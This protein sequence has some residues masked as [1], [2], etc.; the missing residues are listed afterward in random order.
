MKSLAPIFADIKK[1]GK[2]LDKKHQKSDIIKKTM[3]DVSH[4][5]NEVHQSIE[6]YNS[7]LESVL[8][9]GEE[10]HLASLKLLP[11]LDDAEKRCSDLK[12]DSLKLDQ[13]SVV[14]YKVKELEDDIVKYKPTRFK[15]TQVA[16]ELI[17][18]CHHHHVSADLPLIKDE[19]QF[20][21][22]RW[23]RLTS[24]VEEINRQNTSLDKAISKLETSTGVIEEIIEEMEEVV[25]EEMPFSFDFDELD[26]A[27]SE[28]DAKLND[29]KEKEK[30]VS[31]MS[32]N[33]D[34]I[35]SF[36][37][38]HGGD[39]SGINNK[40]DELQRKW[41]TNKNKLSG[42]QEQSR[43]QAKQITHFTKSE[44]NLNDW[45][46]VI[47]TTVPALQTTAS[48]TPDEM[49]KH[50]DQIERIQEEIPK[51][52]IELQTCKEIGDWLCDEFKEQ[53]RPC[54]EIKNKLA[55]I[56]H[57]IEEISSVLSQQESKIYT[58][59]VDNQEFVDALE[60]FTS[61]LEKLSSKIDL[62]KDVSAEWTTLDLQDDK[63]RLIKKKIDSLRY[64][65][66]KVK[67][68]GAELK[69]NDPKSPL[70]EKI[71]DSVKRY[72]D[73]HSNVYSRSTQIEKIVEPSRG[74]YNKCDDVTDWLDKHE[75]KLKDMDLV[76]VTVKDAR[77]MEDQIEAIL[78]EIQKEE[79]KFQEAAKFYK[80]LDSTA[81]K[82][83]ITR[84]KEDVGKRHHKV[85]EQWNDFKKDAHTK[86]DDVTKYKSLLVEFND[87]H[88]KMSV[89]LDRL[90]STCNK[91]VMFGTDDKKT[92]EELEKTKEA[93]AALENLE[94]PQSVLKKACSVLSDM[95][96][97]DGKDA[98]TIKSQADAISEKF[99]RAK[100]S[101]QQ[102]KDDVEKVSRVCSQFVDITKET[103]DWC[104]RSHEA[105]QLFAP[106]GK[107]VEEAN[108]QIHTI[109]VGFIV[110]FFLTKYLDNSFG[111]YDHLMFLDLFFVV[112]ISAK[113]D[114]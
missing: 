66:E 48:P 46:H 107:D 87:A 99:R 34:Q 27:L 111:V 110:A 12:L 60:D 26:R 77:V 15:L 103:E 50:L 100:Q 49:K 36:I 106:V 21:N 95:V 45:V 56:E 80:S 13:K 85:D 39:S 16:D 91:K 25:A 67:E 8:P 14:A 57:P 97:E 63:Q 93:I 29:V 82:E 78:E 52:N 96:E 76:P 109:E 41:N 40:C 90:D 101:A 79:T 74:F 19:V 53:Q 2:K 35:S 71:D 5:W 70:I 28:Q 38:K 32:K 112:A 105:V 98:G 54:A 88:D 10:Y 23:K 58:Q 73:I 113:A 61:Q 114:A 31:E 22:D 86:R 11:W 62:Q 69:K 104:D 51:Q 83:Q 65:Y 42:K 47:S 4:H 89:G 6:K 68:T 81:T 7:K 1:A 37:V 59:L 3:D 64:M 9:L 108:K 24:S 55:C 84:D 72:D 92:S 30:Y 43:D 44:K 33:A 102:K 17:K 94:E 18:K 75:K 20:T